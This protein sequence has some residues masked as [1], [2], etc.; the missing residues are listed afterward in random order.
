MTKKTG[1]R[2]K[3]GARTD[4]EEA[5]DYSQAELDDMA[6]ALNTSVKPAGESTGEGS[7]P[8]PEGL[9]KLRYE[10][11]KIEKEKAVRDAEKAIKEKNLIQKQ[12]D[13]MKAQWQ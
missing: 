13:D 3:N 11:E 4:A 12:L 5:V 10:K 1:K 9:L 2:G 6:A 7:R 8:L